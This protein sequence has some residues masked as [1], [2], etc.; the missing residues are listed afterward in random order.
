MSNDV[1]VIVNLKRDECSPVLRDACDAYLE[2]KSNKAKA[3]CD[4][5]AR[6]ETIWA[7]T[8]DERKRLS[9]SLLAEYESLEEEIKEQKRLNNKLHEMCEDYEKEIKELEETKNKL[10]EL[11]KK[12]NL[13]EERNTTLATLLNKSN[14]TCQALAE[15]QQV[16]RKYINVLLDDIL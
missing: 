2:A 1:R 16:S 6:T 3:F 8:I 7:H 12:V 11:K 14:L 9:D 4:K 13:L 15:E 10:S 5:V